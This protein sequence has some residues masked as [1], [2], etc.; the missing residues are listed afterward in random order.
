METIAL[1]LGTDLTLGL[2]SEVT[3]TAN[4]V[5]LLA[6]RLLHVGNVDIQKIIIETD[7]EMSIHI[8]QCMIS[9][10][11]IDETSPITLNLCLKGINQTIRQIKDELVKIT[12]RLEYNRSLWFGKSIRSYRFHHCQQRLTSHLTVLNSRKQ[13]LIMILSVKDQLI[14]NSEL[15]KIL[16]ESLIAFDPSQLN[17][18]IASFSHKNPNYHLKSP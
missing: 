2:I 7:L 3:S 18:E 12:T 10:I 14:R 11:R 1:K 4:S 15:E 13:L 17:K 6:K 9:E 8:L 16:S 5:Y